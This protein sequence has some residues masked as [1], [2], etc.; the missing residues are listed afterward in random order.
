MTVCNSLDELPDQLTD[1]FLPTARH[2]SVTQ[3]LGFGVWGLGF[4]ARHPSVTQ[5]LGFGV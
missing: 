1:H 5:T 4:T 3:T 2:P